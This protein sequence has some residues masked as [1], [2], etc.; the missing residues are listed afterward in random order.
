MGTKTGTRGSDAPERIMRFF[1][2]NNVPMTAE[3]IASVLGIA[4]STVRHYCED[5]VSLGELE[6][7]RKRNRLYVKA[8]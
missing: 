6:I 3:D 1:E 7:V 2:E 8:S 4:A 5:L